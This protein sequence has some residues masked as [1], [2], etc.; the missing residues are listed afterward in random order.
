MYIGSSFPEGKKK[1]LLLN[2]PPY[3]FSLSGKL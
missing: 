2:F 1:D 3:G